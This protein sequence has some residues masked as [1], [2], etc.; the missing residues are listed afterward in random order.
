MIEVSLKQAAP[1]AID[2]KLAIQH[3][4]D[5]IEWRDMG[6]VFDHS[7]EA[8]TWLKRYLEDLNPTAKHYRLVSVHFH[9]SVMERLKHEPAPGPSNAS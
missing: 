4:D 8:S 6:R 1:T 3:S 9:F 5:G 7:Q 2:G